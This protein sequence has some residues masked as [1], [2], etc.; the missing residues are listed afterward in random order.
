[1]MKRKLNDYF[2][3]KSNFHKTRD[4]LFEKKKEENADDGM[5]Q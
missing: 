2:Q 5:I 3:W 1:M 4:Q